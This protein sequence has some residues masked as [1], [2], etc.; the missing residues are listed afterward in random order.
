MGDRMKFI[1]S[2]ILTL[3]IV[4]AAAAAVLTRPTN[5]WEIYF[6]NQN[7]IVEAENFDDAVRVFR[8]EY[9]SKRIFSVAQ[10]SYVQSIWIWNK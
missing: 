1:L 6:D 3:I 2:F 8:K 7:V 9:K 5:E 4:I 10:R